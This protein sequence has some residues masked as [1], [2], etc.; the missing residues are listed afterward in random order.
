MAVCI[1]DYA[2]EIKKPEEINKQGRV[3]SCLNYKNRIYQ[4]IKTIIKIK[5]MSNK[6]EKMFFNKWNK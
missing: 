3:M 6:I 5:E 4:K 2:Q 1:P